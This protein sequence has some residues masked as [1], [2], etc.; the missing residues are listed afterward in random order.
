MRAGPKS[1]VTVPPLP[2]LGSPRSKARRFE[3]F[4]STYLVT[5]KG[6]GGGKPFR[7]RPW[8]RELVR[9]FYGAGVRQALVSLP[10]GNGKTSLAAALAVF[11]LFD[12]Q[13]F[14][15][16][17][18]CV[19]STQAQAELLLGTARRMVELSPQLSDRAQVYQDK[20][21]VPQTAGQLIALPSLASALQGLDTTLA[22]VDELHVVDEDVWEAI[23]L[24]SGKREHSLTLAISTPS[25]SR[26]SVMWQLVEHGR[27]HSDPSFYFREYAAPGA[28]DINDESAWA[29]ANPALADFLAI[30]ALR[31][32]A[33]TTK[34]T[35]FRRYRLGQWVEHDDVWLPADD[36]TACS[37][38]N[39]DIRGPVTL[40][41][42]GSAS[43]DST[44]IVG[45]TIAAPH[46]VFLVGAW[47]K[48]AHSLQDW[49]VPRQEV[50]AAVDAAFAKFD[51]KELACDPWGWRSEIEQWAGRYGA[52]RVIEWPT[53][54]WSR[55]A[56]AV[57]RMTQAVLERQMTHDGSDVITAHVANSRLKRTPSGDV[58]V[59]DGR[60]SPRKID[61]AVGAVGALSR[62]AHY[63]QNN[64]SR[65]LRAVAA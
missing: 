10:R 54:T 46:H 32:T 25:N 13:V 38:P 60:N 3:R 43:D 52:N 19:A 15:P 9:G 63:A 50:D 12:D 62:A 41:F 47:E 40:F 49:R 5:P 11:E 28:C 34:A 27:S 2:P 45:A 48:P 55:F 24:A 51:V 58:I 17:V 31:S 30:D 39:R 21:L 22:I 1:A 44:V 16:N 14:S 8:Q 36:W 61:A 6:K 53:S 26:S 35:S 33:K 65:Q 57:D 42:D 56:P 64:K 29:E 23:A 18:V 20:I 7:L 4:A 59:K 37:D